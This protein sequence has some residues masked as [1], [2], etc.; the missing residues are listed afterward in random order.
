MMRQVFIIASCL[1]V[2]TVIA[3]MSRRYGADE[4]YASEAISMSTIGF[5]FAAP[6]WLTLVSLM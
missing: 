5:V 4:E 1:P 6:V 2:S 3:V